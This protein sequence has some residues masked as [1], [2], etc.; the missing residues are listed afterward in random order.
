M[1]LT[2]PDS[3]VFD[4]PAG[5]DYQWPENQVPDYVDKTRSLMIHSINEGFNGC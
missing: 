4:W 2:P 5:T 1:Y 3:H